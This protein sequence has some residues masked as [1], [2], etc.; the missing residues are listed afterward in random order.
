MRETVN[1]KEGNRESKHNFGR[2][3]ESKEF[4]LLYTFQIGSEAHPASYPMR[5][6]IPEVKYAG[7]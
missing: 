6:S 7:A 2:V 1:K 4:S 3:P 5:I